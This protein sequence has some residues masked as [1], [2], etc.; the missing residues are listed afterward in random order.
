VEQLQRGPEPFVLRGATREK[1]SAAPTHPHRRHIA[2]YPKPPLLRH[3]FSTEIDSEHPL[4]GP[5]APTNGSYPTGRKF[6][7]E[8]TCDNDALCF[9]FCKSKRF[10]TQLCLMKSSDRAS[11]AS[12]SH[13]MPEISSAPVVA[14]TP[15]QSPS[16]GDRLYT[17]SDIANKL[18]YSP[19]S[20]WRAMQRLDFQ[21]DEV[22]A[23]GQKLYR[24]CR[25]AELQAKLKP[26]RRQ[27]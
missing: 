1:A 14:A 25:L 17:C 10:D 22:T 6:E 23:G 8:E 21:P 24:E 12:Q 13:L 7:V 26:S 4:L 5:I 18:G 9:L 20:I 16:P 3:G 27:R 2:S 11:N 19:S 15:E